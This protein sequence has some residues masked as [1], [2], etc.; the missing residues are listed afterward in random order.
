MNL[1]ELV[2]VTL[3]VGYLVFREYLHY[4]EVE[5]KDEMLKDLE[6]KFAAASTNDYLKMKVASDVPPENM[7]DNIEG[8][9]TIPLDQ[10]D[11]S[12]IDGETK[13]KV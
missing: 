11:Y 8:N 2:I 3:L 9:N 13:L 1:M 6:T 12:D 10:V 4:K 7:S 5:R